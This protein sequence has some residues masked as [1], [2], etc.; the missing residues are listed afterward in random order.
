VV[1]R[2]IPYDRRTSGLFV[3]CHTNMPIELGSF[4]LRKSITLISKRESTVHQTV[5]VDHPVQQRIHRDSQ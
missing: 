5:I 2:R 1:R 3:I 4:D